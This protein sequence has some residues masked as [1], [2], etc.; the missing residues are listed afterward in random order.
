[1]AVFCKRTLGLKFKLIWFFVKKPR[2]FSKP[3]L[4]MGANN[5]NYEITDLEAGAG[6]CDFT[7]VESI[8]GARLSKHNR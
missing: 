1:M 8:L 3:S 7:N 5:C 4:E 2:W 6:V